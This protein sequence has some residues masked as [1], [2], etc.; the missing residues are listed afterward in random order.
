MTRN[1]FIKRLKAG[2]KGMPA[3]DVAEIVGDYEAHFDA[4][5]ADGRSESEV[6][7]ALGNPGRLAR[8][9]R[10]EAGIR[11]WEAGRTPSSAWAAVLAFMGLATI[12]ILILAPI[13]LPIIGV[14]VA[15]YVAVIAVFIAGGF[16]MVVGPFSA[17]PG[18]AIA[19][20]L[21]GLGI[22][23]GS[24]AAGALLTIVSIWVINALMW[25]GRLHYRVIEPAI[26]SDDF[27]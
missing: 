7:E 17:M 10:L 25:F 15:L 22:M 3:E 26:K 9:L 24:V 27:A 5:A 19:A 23:A 8:E 1:E 12:D 14:I 20:L 21:A 13:V 6:A 18:G 16:V 11:N 2:L 4:G